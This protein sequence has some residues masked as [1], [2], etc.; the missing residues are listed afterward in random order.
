M[1]SNPNAALSS[2]NLSVRALTV[3]LAA[4]TAIAP[5]AIDMYLPAMKHMAT[6]FAQPIH[7]IELTISTFLIGYAAGQL[8]GGP[9]SD[10]LGRK[11]TLTIGMIIFI[12]TSLWIA[13]CDSY[14][15]LMLLRTVQ[16]IGGGMATVNSAAM[17]RDLFSGKKVAQMLSMIAVVMMLAPLLAPMIGAGLVTYLDWQSIFYCLAIYALIV[18]IISLKFLP[19]TRS[20]EQKKA[21]QSSSNNIWKNYW[22]VLSHKK[23]MAH[24]AA[25]TLAFSGM[26]VFLTASPYAYMEHFNV[27]SSTFSMLFACNILTMI[28]MNRINVRALQSYSSQQLLQIGLSLQI[29]AGLGLMAGSHF[30]TP[31]W[32][33]VMGNALFVGSIGLVAANAISGCLQYFPHISGTANALIGVIEFCCGALAGFIWSLLHNDTLMPMAFMMWLCAILGLTLYRVLL[34]SPNSMPETPEG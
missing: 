10:R 25:V 6:D 23:A 21:L 12:F 2:I 9:M 1:S 24:V 11:P 14:W 16:A 28:A 29:L 18:M 22:Q 3:L 7:H 33:I 30:D 19:E 8:F 32:F 4:I 15:Q 13:H 31:L 17:I 27:S 26:F 5:F 20:E 34:Y